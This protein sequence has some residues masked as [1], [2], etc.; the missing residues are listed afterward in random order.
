MT[1]RG[2][3]PYP[4]VEDAKA[5]LIRGNRTLTECRCTEPDMSGA[6]ELCVACGGIVR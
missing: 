1:E 6:G 3:E 5:I 2:Y 4:F